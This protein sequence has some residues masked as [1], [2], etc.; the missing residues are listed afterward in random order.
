MLMTHFRRR[1]KFKYWG[2]AVASRSCHR[3]ARVVVASKLAV[4]MRAIWSDGTF[5]VGGSA[6]NRSGAVQRAHI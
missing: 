4:I 5:Y 6:A 3:K 1:D 2:Q